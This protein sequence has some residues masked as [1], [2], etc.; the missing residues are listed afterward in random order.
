[1]HIFK[2]SAETYE[3]VIGNQMHAFL[4]E[5]KGLYVGEV[6]LVSK[7]RSGLAPGEKQISHTMAF[8]DIRLL[9]PGE[10]ERLWPGNE[11]RW[12]YLVIC[13]KTKELAKPFDLEEV[14]GKK[15]ASRYGP[16]ITAGEVKPEDE[17]DIC[18]FLE[19]SE[20]LPSTKPQATAE[21]EEKYE[22]RVT[23]GKA[24]TSNANPPK[25]TEGVGTWVLLTIALAAFILGALIF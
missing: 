23:E 10:T 22:T 5:P 2:T 14:L 19:K 18:S 1:M 21:V 24:Q 3:S 20:V 11:G 15:R 4:G 13:T 7:N 25:Q 6:I 16:I 12:K 8:Q 17:A 9:K